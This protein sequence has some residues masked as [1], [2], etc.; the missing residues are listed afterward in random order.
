MKKTW[1][2]K[3]ISVIIAVIMLL[4]LPISV[5]AASAPTLVAAEGTAPV[6]V[7]NGYHHNILYNYPM[8]GNKVSN[9]AEQVFPP[10]DFNELYTY[11]KMIA[12]YVLMGEGYYKEVTTTIFPNVAEMFT[13]IIC[14][15]DGSVRDNLGVKKLYKSLDYY[16]SD[17][18]LLNEL[19]GDLGLAVAE[20]AG[21]EN[22]YVFTYDWRLSPIVLAKELDAFIEEYVKP[23]SG[24][25]KVTLVSEGI[26]GNVAA[27]YLKKY[28]E[29]L[30]FA[31]I[32]NYVTVNSTAQGMTTIG[33][34]YT[35]QIDVDPN[36][37]VRWFND[38]SDM[39]PVALASWIT[40]YVLNT[41]Y[42]LYHAVGC[43]DTYIIHEKEFIY[44]KY[45]RNI[46]KNTAGLWALIPWTDDDY[47]YFDALDYM[48][49]EGTHMNDVLRNN[50][51]AYREVQRTAADTLVEAKKYGVGVA[52]VS[53]YGLQYYPIVDGLD[54][55]KSAS[56]PSDGIVDTKYSSFGATC[57]YLNTEWVGYDIKEQQIDD[58]HNH[59]NTQYAD[60][61]LFQASVDASTCALP[62]NT[63]F[64]YGLKNDYLHA[65]KDDA[66]Y[67]IASL[68]FMD[69]D[70]TVWSNPYYPQ[71]LTY[72]R[73]RDSLYVYGNKDI[74]Y[75][76]LAGDVNLDGIVTPADARLAL[77]HSAGLLTLTRVRRDNADVNGK[78]KD[79]INGVSAADARL[80]LRY[81]AKLEKE[82]VRT[83]DKVDT[84]SNPD[85]P[86]T[87]SIFDKI[88]GLIK[89]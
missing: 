61:S 51:E 49:P 10:Q 80:I 21:Y 50:V 81:A 39:L 19:A 55:Q 74:N 58:G 52:V 87:P 28:Q 85:A 88:A 4:S 2:K 77:R 17:V 26:G 63:W 20:E 60:H 15:N 48:Y 11:G 89:K 30:K 57:A 6:V 45:V 53:G 35:G 83:V 46:I 79:G 37:V 78:A 24:A 69:K 38:W 7:I 8:A 62:E 64:I 44:D 9:R 75:L 65:A 33:A 18:A 59:L 27:T 1:T 72:N 12:E 56:E 13:N 22:V 82:L 14:N 84:S 41:E 34:L 43:I 36:G 31:G 76:H 73:F 29:P 86:K 54:N 32:Q 16:K 47:A 3:V 66:Y 70:F 40:M 25:D 67:F 23:Q 68:V 71:F 5:L 42:E